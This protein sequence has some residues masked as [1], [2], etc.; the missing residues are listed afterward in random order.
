MP[1][2]SKRWGYLDLYPGKA[3]IKNIH[4]EYSDFKNGNLNSIK[5][6]EGKCKFILKRGKNV[7]NQCSFNIK[8]NEGYCARHHKMLFKNDE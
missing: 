8:T 5:F 1:L 6:I 7:G 4:K 3:P 2:L